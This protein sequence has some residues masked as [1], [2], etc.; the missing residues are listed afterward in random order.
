MMKRFGI[1]MLKSRLVW[2]ILAAGF[3]AAAT[4]AGLSPA[5]VD[6]LKTAVQ[7]AGPE[8]GEVLERSAEGGDAK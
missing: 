4:K 7:T 5:T 8:V 3:G 2:A 1:W 6:T